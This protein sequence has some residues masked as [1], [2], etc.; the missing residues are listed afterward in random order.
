MEER[1]A[2]ISEVARPA[3]SAGELP[4]QQKEVAGNRRRSIFCMDAK[5]WYC[6]SLS[7]Y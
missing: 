6:Y 4:P 7:Y 3:G 2:G 5:K 1:D